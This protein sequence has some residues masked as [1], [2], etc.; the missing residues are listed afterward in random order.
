MIKTYQNSLLLMLIWYDDKVVVKEVTADML[1]SCRT[2]GAPV[3]LQI[4]K[5]GMMV[6]QGAMI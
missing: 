1:I 6:K 3:M 2:W 4:I 5:L